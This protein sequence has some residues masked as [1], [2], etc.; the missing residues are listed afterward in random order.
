LT[1]SGA[2][3]ILQ[4]RR[5]YEL[6]EARQ[7]AVANLKY[8]ADLRVQSLACGLEGPCVAPFDDDRVTGI[9]EVLWMNDEGAIKVCPD[10]HEQVLQDGVRS[11]PSLA[12]RLLRVPL[13]FAPLHVG[14]H[15]AEES[16]NVTSAE[17]VVRISNQTILVCVGVPRQLASP[18]R[19]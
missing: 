2:H 17:T 6:L 3:H 7:F 16:G 12:A 9:V 5:V 10:L 1:L 19:T 8:V 18:G 14:V 13:C 11:V 15:H 4:L